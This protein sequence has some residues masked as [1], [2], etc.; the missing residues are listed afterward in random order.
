MLILDGH[1]SHVSI[2]FV[3]YYVNNKIV[4]LCLPPHS[5]HELQPLDVGA[6]GPLAK[7]YRSLVSQKALF[8]AQRIN[9][10]QFLH[11]YQEARACIPNN[12][13]STW[14]GA[15]LVLFNP[16]KILERYELIVTPFT[17]RPPGPPLILEERLE[18]ISDKVCNVYSTSLK[19]E[20]DFLK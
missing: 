14:R 11:I 1:S 19:K 7:R 12:I 9:N 20:I 13:A 6:F 17:P 15:G 8:G 4:P 5:T 3:Q 2:N 16:K 10:L 18:S